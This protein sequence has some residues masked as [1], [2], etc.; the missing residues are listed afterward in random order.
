MHV[1]FIN[2]YFYPMRK[3]S[4]ILFPV[5]ISLSG[6]LTM[7]APSVKG[8]ENFK[9]GE[10]SKDMNLKFDVGLKNPNNY[11]ITL[12]KM[13]LQLFMNDSLLSD[14]SMDKKTKIVSN[15][16]V[17]IPFT[18]QPKAARLPKLGWSVISDLFG[19]KKDSRV[20]LN[21][22]MIISKFIF[23]KRFKFSVGK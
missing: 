18:V 4:F 20:K 9:M 15:G 21:G 3:F 22:E 10:L 8:I 19:N 14:I 23:R 17:L 7:K 12:R 13:D 2:T 5:L 16:E 1:P 6:C 11:A